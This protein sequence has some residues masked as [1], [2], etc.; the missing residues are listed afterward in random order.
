MAR[1]GRGSEQIRLVDL[2]VDRWLTNTPGSWLVI[3]A[4]KRVFC[5]KSQCEFNEDEGTIT[6][7]EWLAIEKELV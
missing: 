5:P 3:I 2:V 7:P 1:L 6:M 4:G